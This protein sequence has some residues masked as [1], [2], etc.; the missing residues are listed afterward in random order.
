MKYDPNQAQHLR[1]SRETSHI[2]GDLHERLVHDCVA[3][4]RAL[5]YDFNMVEL[6]VQEGKPYAID[7]LNPAPD[8][9]VHSVGPEN[10]EWVVERVAQLTIARA[11]SSNEQANMGRNRLLCGSPEAVAVAGA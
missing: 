5:G 11:T 4:C 8:A 6:A 7:F 3:L 1:Y 9:D 2:P 10:F